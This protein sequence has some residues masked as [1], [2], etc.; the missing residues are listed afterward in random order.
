[1]YKN[2]KF[3]Q[4][5]VFKNISDTLLVWKYIFRIDFTTEYKNKV[6]VYDQLAGYSIRPRWFNY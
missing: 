3:K 1:V 2:K 6:N 5:Q 4:F